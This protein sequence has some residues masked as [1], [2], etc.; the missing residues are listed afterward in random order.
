[1]P[2]QEEMERWMDEM[3]IPEE[4]WDEAGERIRQQLDKEFLETITKLAEV[5]P[6]NNVTADD[7]AA[8]YGTIDAIKELRKELKNAENQST[9]DR[10]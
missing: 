9:T 4:V 1:M 7:L 6:I 8:V 3:S 2:S 5:Q 10:K